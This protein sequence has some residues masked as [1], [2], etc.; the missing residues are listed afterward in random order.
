MVLPS[1]DPINLNHGWVMSSRNMSVLHLVTQSYPCQ[2]LKGGAN[3][4]IYL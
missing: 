2:M 1:T 3:D 4:D